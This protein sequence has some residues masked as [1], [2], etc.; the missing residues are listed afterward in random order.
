M[1]FSIITA[2]KNN[3]EGLLRAIEC[4]RNQT[5]KNVEHIVVDG[6]ST[7]GSVEIL[8]HFDNPSINSGHRLSAGSTQDDTLRQAQGDSNSFFNKS[9]SYLDFNTA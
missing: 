3:K 6:G 9:H 2:T 7:D 5:Y 4:V 8:R 1:R